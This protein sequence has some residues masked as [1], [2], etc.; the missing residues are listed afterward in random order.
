MDTTTIIAIIIGIITV[1]TVVVVI[2][3]QNKRP[4]PSTPTTDCE[5]K[6]GKWEIYNNTQMN[7]Q[8]NNNPPEECR[9]LTGNCGQWKRDVTCTSSNGV[10][11]CTDNDCTGTKPV[12]YIDCGPCSKPNPTPTD[13]DTIKVGDEVNLL[14]YSDDKKDYTNFW[15]GTNDIE[16]YITDV[17]DG[18]RWPRSFPIC[19][20]FAEGKQLGEPVTQQDKITLKVMTKYMN[21][22]IVVYVM[23][24]YDYYFYMVERERLTSSY[25]TK[26]YIRTKDTNGINDDV[27]KY[28]TD[29]ILQDA[30][31]YGNYLYNKSHDGYYSH[32]YVVFKMKD[33]SFDPRIIRL[34]KVV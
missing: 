1:I 28:K 2:V 5:W 23:S 13:D 20:V 12:S 18:S 9:D 26:F 19:R 7:L 4:T 10:G 33:D 31:D 11:N 8:D 24:R 14:Y 30:V 25:I 29:Y 21:E 22:D 34:Q 3:I 6:E 16:G 17:P 15:V 27:L 32:G